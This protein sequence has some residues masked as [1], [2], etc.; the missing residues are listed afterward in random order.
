M[1]RENKDAFGR[2]AIKEHI[3]T[4]AHDKFKELDTNVL[5]YLV[6][7][8]VE[9]IYTVTEKFEEE[10]LEIKDQV[11][12]YAAMHKV[13]VD[14]SVYLWLFSNVSAIYHGISIGNLDE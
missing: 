7:I 6:V 13:V 4:Q 11:D 12:L 10:T 9:R 1:A 5:W 3:Y 2:I 14:S 8:T